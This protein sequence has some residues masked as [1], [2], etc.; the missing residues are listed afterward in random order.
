MVLEEG[1]LNNDLS[2]AKIEA[3]DQAIFHNLSS[4]LV[5]GVR[6]EDR[7]RNVISWSSLLK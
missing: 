7:D 5:T 3:I 2:R 1:M 6:F 4:D